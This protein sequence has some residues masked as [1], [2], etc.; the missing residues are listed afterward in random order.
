[1]TKGE[2][3]DAGDAIDEVAWSSE[4]HNYCIC[5]C[6]CLI[7]REVRRISGTWR[8]GEPVI[9]TNNGLARV[10]NFGNTGLK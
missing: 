4:G 5:G 2:I 10:P 8:K 3:R 9:L 1:M 6:G 7:E